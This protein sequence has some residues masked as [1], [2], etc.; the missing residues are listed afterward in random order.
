M[1]RTAIVTGGTGGLGTA[2]VGRLID[3][4]WRVVVPWV[5]EQE[6]DRVRLREELD[7]VQA[8][9]FEPAAV[10][11]VIR[12][13]TAQRDAPLRGL[14]NLVGGFSVGARVHETP[15]D[16]VEHQLRLNL[17]GLGP[18]GVTRFLG[19]GLVRP[20]ELLEELAVNILA[21]Q[22]GQDQAAVLGEQVT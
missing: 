19:T 7:L 17:R 12:T 18:V 5:I 22:P 11:H 2:V 3:D 8:D 14:V 6:L 10:A 20:A 9:L 15:V 21:N 4:D 1:A 16:E 13:A